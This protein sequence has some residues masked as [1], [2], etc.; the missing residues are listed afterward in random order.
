MSSTNDSRHGRRVRFSLRALLVDTSL[1]AVCLALLRLIR[2]DEA[3]PYNL[4]ISRVALFGLF[5]LGLVLGRTCSL[6]TAWCVGA[7]LGGSLGVL[8]AI[9]VMSVGRAM[10]QP[11]EFR[12]LPLKGL[13]LLPICFV[14]YGAPVG[15]SFA[16]LHW[17]QNWGK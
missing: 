10:P 14:A 13:I 6:R 1:I 12:Q 8:G 15:A 3:P 2:P 17:V 11:T 7:V 4:L 9:Y 5:T 16:A